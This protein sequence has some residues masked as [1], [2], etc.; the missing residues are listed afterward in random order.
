[1][2]I[3]YATFGDEPDVVKLLA[4]HGVDLN[5]RNRRQQTPL[6]IAV[7]KGHVTIIRVLL[8]NNCHPS[9][10]VILLIFTINGNHTHLGLWW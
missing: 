8:E 3:H 5:A 1:M 7:T 4:S 6:H 10:Q 2:A 9:L